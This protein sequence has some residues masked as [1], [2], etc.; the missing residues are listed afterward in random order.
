M[1]QDGSQARIFSLTEASLL[2]NFSKIAFRNYNLYSELT[3]IEFFFTMLCSAV[4][5]Q[6][7]EPFA[8]T[9]Y[10]Y[11]AMMDMAEKQSVQGLIIECLIHSQTKLEKKCVI[12][13]MKVKNA[14]AAE[15]RKLNQRAVEVGRLFEE[16]GFRYCII[17]GQGNTLMY[18]NPMSRTPGD[19]DIWIE[20]TR[21]QI[22]QFVKD[23][24]P[25]VRDGR[26]HIYI[27]IF[28]DAEVE[29]HYRPYMM[30]GFISDKR[31]RKWASENAEK[32]FSHQVRLPETDGFVNIST[33]SF[34]II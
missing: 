17:K 33:P 24:C 16:A 9:P 34:N 13:M 19:I 10:E 2:D 11:K 1:R 28:D 22:S 31:L 21:T 3:K 5:K 18:P 14:F 7:M 27:P 25:G 6:P 8:M 23:K 4:I 26:L 30:N 15:N 29:V 20:G 32:Q 12:H